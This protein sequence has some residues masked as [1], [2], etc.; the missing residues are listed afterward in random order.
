MISNTHLLKVTGLKVDIV[1]GVM[2]ENWILIDLDLENYSHYS[3]K[4]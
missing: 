4:Y 1:F 2:D 3:T